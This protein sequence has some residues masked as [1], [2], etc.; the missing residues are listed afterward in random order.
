VLFTGLFSLSAGL[1]EWAN[2]RMRKS[3]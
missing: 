1:D 3:V 2:P